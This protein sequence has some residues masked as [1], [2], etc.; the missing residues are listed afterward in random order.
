LTN[1]YQHQK[2]RSKKY[3]YELSY[4]LKELQ[5]YLTNK[6]FQELFK[7]WVEGGYMYYDKPSVD[8]INAN[9][10]Y[11]LDNI[12]IMSWKE[13]RRKGDKEVA[14]KKWKPIIM[15]DMDGTH[16]KKYVSI[17]SAVED[18]GYNQGLIS[19]VLKGHRNHTG[20]FKFIY[21]NPEL[22]KDPL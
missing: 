22:L 17:K 12:Q 13:N 18:T 3:G 2:A 16:L 10:G 6:K 4:S 21:Q 19:M 5:F 7:N 9:R 20:G 8:R 11:T 15:C 14:R 1:I